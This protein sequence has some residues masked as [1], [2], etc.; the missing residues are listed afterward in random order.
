VPDW[1]P[2]A[3]R[4]LAPG[5]RLT[6]ARL[7]ALLLVAVATFATM[8]ALAL[9]AMGALNGL[10]GQSVDARFA[11]RGTEPPDR[12]IAIV[13]LDPKTLESLNVQSP[14]PRGYFA[15][16]LDRLKAADARLIVLDFTF[17][18]ASAH[19]NQDRALLAAIARDGP[20]VMGAPDPG[21]STFRPVGA[22]RG[23]GAVL[24]S[25]AV[26]N[27]PD[28]VI[29]QMLYVQVSLQTLAV[30]AAAVVMNH[31]VS[32]ADFPGNHAWIDFR[33]PPGT[34]PASSMA[35]VLDGSVPLSRFAGK[36][37]LV[38]TT[39]PLAEWTVSLEPDSS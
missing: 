29:R 1:L 4:R 9:D 23:P 38:G 33:G 17:A 21:A 31:A 26:D 6:P 27:N 8:L 18:G 39:D 16:L 12:R 13:A 35:D 25:L 36:V 30:R 5:S 2:E 22:R 34:F 11:V 3:I 32:E 24:A 28:G 37:V 20:V 7:R 15:H 10:E 14:I 19:P